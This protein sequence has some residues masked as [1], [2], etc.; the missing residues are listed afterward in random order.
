MNLTA[1]HLRIANLRSTVATIFSQYIASAATMLF[2]VGCQLTW[3]IV[4]AR[5]LGVAQIGELMV[6]SGVGSMASTLCMW[7]SGDA[8][9]RH[10]ARQRGAYAQMLGHGLLLIG[11]I[12][13]VLVILS[14][15]L[16]SLLIV[17][18]SVSTTSVALFS[19][20]NIIVSSFIGLAASAFMGFGNF[21]VANTIVAGSSLT[22]L[23]SAVT[24][25]LVFNVTTLDEWA[26]WSTAAN[27]LTA[28]ACSLVLIPLGRPVW[29]INR[30]ELVRGF[31]FTTPRF[32]ENLR[33]NVDRV[34][35]SIV[36]PASV[37]GSYATAM[38][39]TLTSQMAVNSLNRIVYPRFARR[40]DLGIADSLPLSIAYGLVVT[41]LSSMTAFGVY[42]I[43]PYLPIIL[44]ESY[45]Q[46]IFDLQVLCWLIVPVSIRTVPY[47]V[48]GAMDQHGLRAKYFNS[49][50]LVGIIGTAVAIYIFGIT[51]AFV[52]VYVVQITLTAGLWFAIVRAAGKKG[53]SY[54]ASAWKPQVFDWPVRLQAIGFGERKR[55]RKDAT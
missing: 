1:Q 22:R 23:L 5:S 49:I 26:L 15:A 9:I 17:G 47:D 44:G 13:S 50:S 28:L 33:Q 42:L 3:F 12:G 18:P 6:I 19:I 32:I 34:V 25:C 43:A 52:S 14:V 45:R 16:L 10:T 39:V 7:G 2:S 8:M 54:A 53:P 41:C 11:T 31:H 35:L 27:L 55:R 51:G 21:R 29:R 4:L 20:T 46:A 30:S 40:I 36:V 37:L 48:F 24:A 38:R